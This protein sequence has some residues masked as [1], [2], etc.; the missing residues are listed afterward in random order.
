MHAMAAEHGLPAYVVYRRQ[1]EGWSKELLFAPI[2]TR[3]SGRNRRGRVQVGAEAL[4]V[5][6]IAR[7]SGASRDAIAARLRAGWTGEAL[8][9]PSRKQA[10]RN[11]VTAAEVRELIDSGLSLYQAAHELGVS[12]QTIKRRLGS[13]G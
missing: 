5:A 3:R 2:G 11:A 13:Q 4:T 7:R 12:H 10:G 9:K 6:E 1:R 8:L